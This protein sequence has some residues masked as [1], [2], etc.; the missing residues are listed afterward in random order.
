MAGHFPPPE[1]LDPFGFRQLFEN[2]GCIPGADLILRQEEHAHAVVP[3]IAQGNTLF[4]GPGRKERVGQLRHNAYAVAGG[5]LRVA[6]RPVRQ[7]LNNAQRLV[8]RPVGRFRIQ[9]HH[10][11]HAAAVMFQFF[12]IKRILSVPHRFI[13]PFS[14]DLIT[15]LIA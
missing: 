12:M 1:H 8:H 4:P 13:P 14:K 10:G 5:S 3:R 15:Q 9:V 11:A 7:P 2:S 6:S